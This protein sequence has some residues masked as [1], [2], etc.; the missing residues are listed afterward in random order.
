MEDNIKY[1]LIGGG[2]PRHLNT[3]SN[4]YIVTVHYTYQYMLCIVD[5]H[6]YIPCCPVQI[7]PNKPL[8]TAPM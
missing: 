8:L 1:E 7:N 6:V 5:D 2:S 3:F 4:L